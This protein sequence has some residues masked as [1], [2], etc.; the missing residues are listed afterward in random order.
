MTEYPGKIYILEHV[1]INGLKKSVINLQQPNEPFIII[2]SLS[3]EQ[4]TYNGM[5]II[6]MGEQTI[7]KLGRSNNNEIIIKDISVSRN[8][9]LIKLE[10]QSKLV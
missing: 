6:T 1:T 2:D 5:Y 8:H 7:F 4:S 9:A 10:N 3:K